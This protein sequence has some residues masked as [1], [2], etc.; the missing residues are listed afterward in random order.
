MWITKGRLTFV[1]GFCRA[2]RRL[3][4]LA[5]AVVAGVRQA[6]HIELDW[7]TAFVASG[8]NE[9]TYNAGQ[10][11]NETAHGLLPIGF[12]LARE[13]LPRQSSKLK[14]RHP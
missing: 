14:Q 9:T 13:K 10:G 12:C 3:S 4:F 8:G 1:R 6:W 2:A 11:Q 5:R 7:I